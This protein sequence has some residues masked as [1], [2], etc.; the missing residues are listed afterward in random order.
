MD[1][2]GQGPRRVV[3]KAIAC[4]LEVVSGSSTTVTAVKPHNE[5]V[6]GAQCVV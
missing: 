5:I 6:P 2:F 1:K 4:T 3:A